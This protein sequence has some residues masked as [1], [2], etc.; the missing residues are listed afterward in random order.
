MARPR[1]N[2][3]KVTV[4]YKDGG[5]FE[6]KMSIE[7]ETAGKYLSDDELAR[8]IIKRS[9]FGNESYG[10]YSCNRLIDAVDSGAA[11]L[12][13]FQYAKQKNKRKVDSI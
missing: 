13:I 11:S 7:E 1:K 2:K 10:L 12:S 6:I 8:Y 4:L 9:G 3:Y 5:S